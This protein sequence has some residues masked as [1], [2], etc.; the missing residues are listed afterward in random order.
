M[1]IPRDADEYGPMIEYCEYS[2]LQNKRLTPAV[3]ASAIEVLLCKLVI[4]A[5]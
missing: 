1:Q 3:R 4:R 5:H 2:F